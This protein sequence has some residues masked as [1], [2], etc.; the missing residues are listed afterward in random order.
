MN[1]EITQILEDLPFT[2]LRIWSDLGLPDKLSSS[3]VSDST[4]AFLVDSV[5]VV[6]LELSKDRKDR[7][8]FW[9]NWEYEIGC[10]GL[11][12]DSKDDATNL[13]IQK[14]VGYLVSK[15]LKSNYIP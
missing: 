15:E 10:S 7:C 3:I 4:I 5:K 8:S 14:L 13:I 2:V 12:E 6:E 1:T 9:V 11:C